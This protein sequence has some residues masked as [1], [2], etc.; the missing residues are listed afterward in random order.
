MT[1]WLEKLKTAKDTTSEGICFSHGLKY[2]ELRISLLPVPGIFAFFRRS[3][4]RIV[5]EV[6]QDEM[7]PG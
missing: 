4:S 3:L 7:G 5:S 6:S 1:E 2:A